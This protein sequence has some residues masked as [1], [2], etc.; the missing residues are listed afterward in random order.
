MS[1]VSSY[2]TS[3]IP[4]ILLAPEMRNNLP[5]EA[6]GILFKN[7]FTTSLAADDNIFTVCVTRS[8]KK[9]KKKT[10]DLLGFTLRTGV[11]PLNSQ[12]NL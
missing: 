1:T 11:H 12:Y 7:L 8:A 6:S 5:L 4:D 10:V 2:R 3:E 9:K